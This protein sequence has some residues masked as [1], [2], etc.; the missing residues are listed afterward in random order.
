MCVD[1]V[2]TTFLSRF[3]MESVSILASSL[4]IHGFMRNE[5]RSKRLFIGIMSSAKLNVHLSLNAQRK[6]FYLPY[7]ACSMP[8][9]NDFQNR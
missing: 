4:K 2:W 7:R 9:N 3:F 5:V 1:K 6:F 8:Y